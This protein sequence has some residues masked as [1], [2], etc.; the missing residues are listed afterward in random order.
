[1]GGGRR[2]RTTVLARLAGFQTGSWHQPD[3]LRVRLQVLGARASPRLRSAAGSPGSSGT[4]EAVID[5]FLQIGGPISDA[6]A[7]F[8]PRGRLAEKPAAPHGCNR[9]PE[10]PRSLPFI[11]QDFGWLSMCVSTRKR[12][13]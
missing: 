4:N 5:Q 6:R 10:S 13:H 1:M 11:N 7:Q 2:N 8:H 12:F 3:A 9:Q